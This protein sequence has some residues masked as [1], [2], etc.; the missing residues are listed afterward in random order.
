M[1]ILEDVTDRARA[2]QAL[3]WAHDTL[4]QRV[5]ERT[6]ELH[7]QKTVLES[8]SQASADGILAL[9]DNGTVIFANDRF[10]EMWRVRTEGNAPQLG[11]IRGDMGRQMASRPA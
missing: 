2:R 8:Q 11:R 9:A 3:Q 5:R 4:E 7:F 1:I 10:K 6:A